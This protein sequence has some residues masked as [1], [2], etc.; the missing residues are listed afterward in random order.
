MLSSNLTLYRSEKK[1]CRS[2]LNVGAHFHG[3]VTTSLR[4][5]THFRWFFMYTSAR[6]V[7]LSRQEIPNIT[8]AE[9]CWDTYGGKKCPD[10][11]A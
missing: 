7:V 11:Y 1:F 3:D 4:K 2:K 8:T 9:V 5:K 6:F 10:S